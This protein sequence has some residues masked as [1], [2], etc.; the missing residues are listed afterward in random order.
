MADVV[1]SLELALREHIVGILTSDH[2]MPLVWQHTSSQYGYDITL[3]IEMRLNESAM[4]IVKRALL[5]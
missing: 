1:K 2:P 5:E 3:T 4:P